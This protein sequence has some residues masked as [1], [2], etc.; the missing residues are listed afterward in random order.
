MPSQT[1]TEGQERGCG[2]TGRGSRRD[3][4]PMTG[5]L[6][7]FLAGPK[8]TVA[9][10]KLWLLAFCAFCKVF[11]CVNYVQYKKNRKGCRR[12]GQIISHSAVCHSPFL[13]V[14]GVFWFQPD[15]PRNQRLREQGH[16]LSVA[17][18]ADGVPI[19]GAG[20]ANMLSVAHT[21]CRVPTSK[22]MSI[23]PFLPKLFRPRGR[24]AHRRSGWL[25]VE[26]CRTRR[27]AI[28]S[29]SLR[30]SGNRHW[31]RCNGVLGDT[32]LPGYRRMGVQLVVG[33]PDSA[34][35]EDHHFARVRSM[36]CASA[37]RGAVP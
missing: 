25:K 10:C 33:V 12:M 13:G 24:A 8:S 6:F 4:I 15:T 3:V 9:S 22:A 31:R 14:S 21:G 37:R 2:S 7:A 20:M 19:G 32:G 27:T 16:Q 5:L 1:G 35:G 36:T 11:Q 34:Y 28:F 30:S 18:D 26:S 17:R 23:N 29:W